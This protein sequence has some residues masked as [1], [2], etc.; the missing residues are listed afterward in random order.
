MDDYLEYYNDP[1]FA[2]PPVKY[3]KHA[4]QR[5][6]ER[7]PKTHIGEKNF[8]IVKNN[9][10]VTTIIKNK[11]IPSDDDIL[12]KYKLCKTIHLENK[13]IGRLIGKKGQNIKTLL[14]K[15]RS[16]AFDRD[17]IYHISNDMVNNMRCVFI[18]AN[19]ENTYYIAKNELELFIN[20]IKQSCLKQQMPVKNGV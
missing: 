8:N 16:K 19:N 18:L 13:Y 2:Q 7:R 12:K 14:Y 15:V 1:E 9:V 3:S 20:I 4:L 5:I 10:V 6:K 17:I 11:I